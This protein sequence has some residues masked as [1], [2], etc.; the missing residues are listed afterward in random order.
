[1]TGLGDSSAT[2]ITASKCI[3]NAI[4]RGPQERTGLRMERK[5][6]ESSALSLVCRGRPLFYASTSA[7]CAH[8][9]LC[10]I[11]KLSPLRSLASMQASSVESRCNARP[12]LR[13]QPASI[14]HRE[15]W[16]LKVVFAFGAWWRQL[17]PGVA[18]ADEKLWCQITNID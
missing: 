3:A 8:I 15:P 14:M 13:P 17:D 7:L 6:L 16:W 9:F 4:R 18:L 10:A 1:M 5:T 11:C 12:Q 2:L